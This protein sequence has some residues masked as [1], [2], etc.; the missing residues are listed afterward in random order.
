MAVSKEKRESR[1]RVGHWAISHFNK[2]PIGRSKMIWWRRRE[3]GHIAQRA[4][5]LKPLLAAVSA[6]LSVLFKGSFFEAS[7]EMPM[8]QPCRFLLPYCI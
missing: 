6:A 7:A 1:L 3:R 2:G 5:G 4:P 8:I